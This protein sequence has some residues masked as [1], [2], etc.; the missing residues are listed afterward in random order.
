[1]QEI[2][3]SRIVFHSNRDTFLSGGD[4]IV[5]QE[6]TDSNREKKMKVQSAIRL[7]FHVFFLLQLYSGTWYCCPV[8]QYFTLQQYQDELCRC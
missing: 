4:E 7:I 3:E 6:N 1:V 2:N 5:V 8:V